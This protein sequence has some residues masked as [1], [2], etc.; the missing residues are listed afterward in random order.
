MARPRCS[1]NEPKRFG[2]MGA[3]VRLVSR[4]TVAATVGFETAVCAHNNLP[5]SRSDEQAAPAA[6]DC[7]KKRRR[8]IEGMEKT[9][10]LAWFVLYWKRRIARSLLSNMT[11]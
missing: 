9:S 5:N 7:C 10:K 6:I 11:L 3:T 4:Y 2:S 1:R 8:A